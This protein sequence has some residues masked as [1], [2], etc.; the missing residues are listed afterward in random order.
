MDPVDIVSIDDSPW[1]FNQFPVGENIHYPH[2]GNDAAA[3]RQFGEAPATPLQ[4]RER[5][6]SVRRVLLGN[7]LDDSFEVESRRVCPQDFEISHPW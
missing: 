5:G 1:P 6:E 3:F 4:S 7:E 2:L